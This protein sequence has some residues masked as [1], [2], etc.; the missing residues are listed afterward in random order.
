MTGATQ[1]AEHLA[2]V[3]TVAMGLRA[4]ITG[5]GISGRFAFRVSNRGSVIVTVDCAATQ[6]NLR[7]D[8]ATVMRLL[9]DA[10]GKAGFEADYGGQGE[11]VVRQRAAV[12]AAA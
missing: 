8:T 4:A 5:S 7:Q 10:C 9:R 6:G 1:T 12:Q 2:R 3:R 11:V